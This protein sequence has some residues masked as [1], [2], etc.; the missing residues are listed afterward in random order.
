MLYV[1]HA[2]YDYFQMHGV[3]ER[4]LFFF[5]PTPWITARFQAEPERVQ[6]EARAWR[7]RLGIPDRDLLILFAG[8][9]EEKKRPLDLLAAF[10]AVGP[11]DV[12]LLFVGAGEQENELRQ[13]AAGQS[14]VF[15]APFQNQSEMPRTYAACDLFVLP[16]FGAKETWGLAINEA[17]CW[18]S[19]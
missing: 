19:P 1:G 15:F 4:K 9:F 12:S 2:N 14:R 13:A 5:R 11:R 3:P 8:K 6:A 18:K 17:L 16:S 7:R 10:K